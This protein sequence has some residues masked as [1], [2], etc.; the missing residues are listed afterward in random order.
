MAFQLSPGVLVTERD[1]TTIVPAVATTNAA[2]AGLFNWGPVNKV[3]LIDSENNLVKTFGLP[4][5][6]NY[7]YFFSAANFLSYGNNLSVARCLMNGSKSKNAVGNGFGSPTAL[8][9]ESEDKVNDAS[10]SSQGYFMARYPGTLGNSLAIE[11]C[12]ATAVGNTLGFNSWEYSDEFDRAPGSSETVSALGG[13]GDSFHLVVVDKDGLW[14]GASGSVLE[15]Y[16]NL[17][18]HSEAYDANGVSKFFRSRINEDSSYILCPEAPAWPNTTNGLTGF[19]IGMASGYTA[20]FQDVVFGGLT[21]TYVSFGIARYNLAGGV[22][23]TAPSSVSQYTDLAFGGPGG[24]T[25]GYDLFKDPERVDVNL[26][27]G[28]PEFQPTDNSVSGT[29]AKQIK[30]R[31]TDIRKDCVLFCSAPISNPARKEDDKLAVAKAYRNDIGSSSYVVIDS[32][33]KYMYD[34]YNDKYRWVP[35]NGDIAGLCARTDL[36]ND[37]WWSPAGFNRGQVKGAIKLAFNPSATF[38]DELYKNNINPVVQF[39][40]EGVVLYGDKTAQARPSAFD[41]IN[42]RRLFIVLEKAIATA[43]KYSLFEFNDSFTRAQFRSLV[44]P[45]LRDVQSRRGIYDFKVVCDEKNNTP[46]VIDSNRFVADIYIKPARSI[47]FI[48]LN[49]IATRT[50]VNFSEVGA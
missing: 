4:D 33:Y 31:I 3:V 9:I 45:F 41:R 30:D 1:L 6:S 48:Q 37:P 8:L 35:L 42:V 5:D 2:F 26:I 23:E 11:I 49:F 14:T 27:I 19:R 34:I 16:E 18:V 21:G 17:S 50:G 28:G 39:P 36:T 43:S 15:R 46:E 25:G 29:V 40:G 24:T 44:E 22:G 12:G 32:G 38:R 7:Q 13:S 47:N 20:Q 10:A